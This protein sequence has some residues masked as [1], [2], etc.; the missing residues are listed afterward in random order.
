MTLPATQ[1]TDDPYRLP[2]HVT[3]ARYELR[4]EPDLDNQT[5]AGHVTITVTVHEP[6]SEILL[7]VAE[8]EVTSAG[9]M[10][11]RGITEKGTIQLQQERQRCCIRFASTCEA[12]NWQLILSFNGTLNDKLRGFYRSTYKDSTGVNHILAATQ[13]E[14]TDARRAFPC[15]DE[16][17]FK[18]IFAITMVIDPNL[19]AV[20]NTAVQAEDSH[21]GKKVLRFSDTIKMSTYLVAFIVGNLDPHPFVYG[22]CRVNGTWHP[23]ARKSPAFP[24]LSYRT[25]MAFLIPV[26]SSI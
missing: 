14:A 6:T 4:L 9:M 16:P 22:P 2:R 15:W 7:N 19:T 25:T 3:P 26:T 24:C 10:D 12:G 18:A 1:I 8:L 17:D 5:F 20:S 21:A 11:V 13:F 23:S